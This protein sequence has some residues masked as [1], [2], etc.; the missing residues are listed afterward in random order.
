[1]DFT[2]NLI[3]TLEDHKEVLNEYV[4]ILGTHCPNYVHGDTVVRTP[5]SADRMMSCFVIQP[6]TH[7]FQPTTLRHQLEMVIIQYLSPLQFYLFYLRTP[8]VRFLV[9][10]ALSTSHKYLTNH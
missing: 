8:R 4:P 10:G 5:L 9:L 7:R 1:M 6:P 2:H 3:H